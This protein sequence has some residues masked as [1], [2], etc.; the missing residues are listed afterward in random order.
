MK[1]IE[2]LI[3]ELKH[4]NIEQVVNCETYSGFEDYIPAAVLASL[5]KIDNAWH[6]V[7]Q[8]RSKNI[9]APGQI[10]F[11]GGKIDKKDK[12][13]LD[14]A[15]RETVEELG[16]NKEDIEVI[17]KFKTLI[18]PSGMLIYTYLGILH[19]TL[20]QLNVNQN[21]VEKLIVI[22]IPFFIDTIPDE[23]D[24]LIKIQPYEIDKETNEKTVLFPAEELGLSKRYYDSWGEAKY[25]YYFYHYQGD[26]I[27]GM[28]ANMI[29]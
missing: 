10:S 1:E 11:P 27:W 15:I 25:T 28:T 8:K 6:F 13:S 7:F 24:C 20:D 23:Y 2:Q 3:E 14:T 22:P 17:D 12:S 26:I 19:T 9:S 21:E 5:I 29:K 4:N 18:I 16:C